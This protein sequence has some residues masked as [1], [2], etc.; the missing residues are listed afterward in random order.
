MSA[1]GY[2]PILTA[3]CISLNATVFSS[4]CVWFSVDGFSKFGFMQFL[5]GQLGARSGI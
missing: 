4:V 5:N 2:S 1:A 3:V